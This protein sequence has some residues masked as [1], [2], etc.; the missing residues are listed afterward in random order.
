MVYEVLL[1]AALLLV[2]GFVFLRFVG[3]ID[4]TVRPFFQIYLLIIVGIYFVWFWSHGGQTVAMKAW[5]VR[6]VNDNGSRITTKQAVYRYLLAL[7]SFG[8][9]M[10]GIAWAIVDP[11][12]KFLH[13]R[14]VK[15]TLVFE[16]KN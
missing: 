5:R 3:E 6:L 7:L 13:D 8:L 12:H 4:N 16:P 10:V 9:T 14:L 1:L 2:A 11:D 15:T